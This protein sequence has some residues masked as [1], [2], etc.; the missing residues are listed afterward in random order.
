MNLNPA[1]LNIIFDHTYSNV[2]A[3]VK[4]TTLKKW[5]ISM[6]G[7]QNSKLKT[8]GHYIHKHE[9]IAVLRMKMDMFAKGMLII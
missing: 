1:Q 4:E 7:P 9:G 6:T 2:D 8:S 3:S 5:K